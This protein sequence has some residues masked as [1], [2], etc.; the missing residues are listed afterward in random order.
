MAAANRSNQE[1]L[2]YCYHCSK[3]F[4][5][6]EGVFL[7]SCDECFEAGH[8]VEEGI[9]RA[10]QHNM[11]V[12]LAKAEVEYR[13]SR[14]LQDVRPRI[15]VDLKNPNVEISKENEL[16]WIKLA[17]GDRETPTAA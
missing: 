4:E 16:D 13:R 9:C 7:H 3:D 8:K 11:K 12:T 2:K 14:P 15:T 1:K 6:P 5:G 10:C 17:T